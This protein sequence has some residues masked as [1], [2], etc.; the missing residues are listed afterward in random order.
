MHS[1]SL[2]GIETPVPMTDVVIDH[3]G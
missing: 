3:Y 1:T 2:Q